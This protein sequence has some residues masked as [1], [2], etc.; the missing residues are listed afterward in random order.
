MVRFE[1]TSALTAGQDLLTPV[2]LAV[3]SASCRDFPYLLPLHLLPMPSPTKRI[4]VLLRPRVLEVVED[5][6]EKEDFTLSKT[7][8][9]LVEEAL[10]SRG[11]FDKGYRTGN[12][13][14]LALQKE[15]QKLQ[16]E[17]ER[18]EGLE[19]DE[20]GYFFRPEEVSGL[21]KHVTLVAK[22]TQAIDDED[23]ALLKKIKA[24]KDVGL[25]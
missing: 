18:E 5:L 2:T 16:T 19:R 14:A 4:Q 11:L 25:L 12:R 21:G 24:L 3:H 7:V 15:E 10:I 1:Q 9:M 22:K 20:D 6:S 17:L 23:L 8:S 13:E